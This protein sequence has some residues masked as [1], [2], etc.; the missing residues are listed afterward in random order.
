MASFVGVGLNEPL[1]APQVVLRGRGVDSPVN[2][3]KVLGEVWSG[4]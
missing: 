1:L 4:G 3:E 2:Y